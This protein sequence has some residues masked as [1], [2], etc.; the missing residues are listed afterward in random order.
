MVTAACARDN[1]GGVKNGW[2]YVV[3]R[4][5]TAAVA[6]MTQRFAAMRNSGRAIGFQPFRIMNV[7]SRELSVAISITRSD[8]KTL[9]PTRLFHPGA[10]CRF[11]KGGLPQNRRHA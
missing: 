4:K 9:D 6:A 1:S 8:D 3:L 5:K 11:R 7:C 10:G 2:N